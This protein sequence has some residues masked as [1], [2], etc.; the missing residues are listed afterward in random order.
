MEQG[1]FFLALVFNLN[2]D[3]LGKD[4]FIAC[5]TSIMKYS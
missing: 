3:L 5:E 4:H 2:F 1:P